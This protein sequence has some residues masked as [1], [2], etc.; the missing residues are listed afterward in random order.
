MHWGCNSWLERKTTEVKVSTKISRMA[1][2]VTPTHLGQ[3]LVFCLLE[4]KMPLYMAK[5]GVALRA[6][7]PLEQGGTI[8][9][10]HL[11]VAQ[12]QLLDL[13]IPTSPR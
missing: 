7:S 10:K 11:G 13:R 3:D 2:A 9:T 6:R 4:Y 8:R 1:R 12:K 5:S